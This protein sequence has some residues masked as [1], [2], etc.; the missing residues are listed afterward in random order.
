MMKYIN[1][2]THQF[3]NR[4]GFFELV[5]QYPTDFDAEIPFY[6]IGIHPWHCDATRLAQDLIFIESK[7]Q[8]NSCL[9]IGEC[10]LDKRID[11]PLTLQLEVFEKQLALAELY[12]KPVIIHCV[13][14]F[15]EL[16]EVKNRLKITVPMIVH[17]FSK[18]EHVANQLLA[19]GFYISFGKYLLKDP[20]LEMV[21]KTIPNHQ[22]F[23][24]TD[25]LVEGIETVYEVAAKYKNLE[26]AQLH[27][28]VENNFNRV[29]INKKT[30]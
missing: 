29:F 17:G 22:F 19:N 12:K 15:Q 16:I 23:L 25:T 21:F 9:A 5:N 4:V 26:L 11:H 6:S 14:A 1:L 28:I 30:E 18:N 8:L 20:E 13:A 27:H 2:H 3:S 10:G 24:E 7:L